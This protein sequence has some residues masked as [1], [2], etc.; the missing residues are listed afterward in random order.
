M[1]TA[2]DFKA[3]AIWFACVATPAICAALAVN[4]WMVR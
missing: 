1:P 2:K 4:A 3:A